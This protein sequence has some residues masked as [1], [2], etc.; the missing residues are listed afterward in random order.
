MRKMAVH[1]LGYL[2]IQTL[3]QGTGD[4]QRPACKGIRKKPPLNYGLPMN[5]RQVQKGAS[6]KTEYLSEDQ[7]G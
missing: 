5:R 6:C 3:S 4:L 2:R 7:K 1:S